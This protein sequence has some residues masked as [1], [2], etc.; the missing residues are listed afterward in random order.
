MWMNET[1]AS[2]MVPWYHFIGAEDGLGADR[3]WQEPGRRYF[4]WLARHD[5][6]F[7]NK[8]SIANIAVVMGQ[9]TQMFYQSPGKIDSTFDVEGLY[10]ALLEGRFLFDFVHEDDLDAENL[11]KYKVL[12]LPNTALLSDIPIAGNSNAFVKSGGS[13]LASFETSMYTDQNE[14]RP[15]FGIADVFWNS[16]IRSP[17]VAPYTCWLNETAMSRPE[18]LTRR[19]C[20][21]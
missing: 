4:N 9:R 21:R 1:V 16:K 10:Y 18:N 6:H 12:L 19:W 2:G 11:K 8:R 15:D 3:R 7:K 14:R 13:L 20:P 5:Q 17:F